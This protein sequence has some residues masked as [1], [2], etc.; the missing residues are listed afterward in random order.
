M[1]QPLVPLLVSAVLLSGCGANVPTD[2]SEE[3]QRVRVVPVAAETVSEELVWSGQITPAETVKLSF[4]VA[5][6]IEDVYVHAGETVAAGQVLAR[7][8]SADYEIQTRAAAAALQAATVQAEEILPAKLRQARAQLDLTLANY[9][10]IHSL[11]EAGAVTAVAL[12]EITAKKAVD[13]ATWTQA[14]EALRIGRAEAER[15][16]AAYDLPQ[17]NLAATEITSPWDGQVLQVI[18]AAGESTAAGYPVLALGSTADMWA[19]IGLTD[20][21]TARLTTGLTTDV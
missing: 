17:S 19:E 11:Y 3:P 6:V 2:R 15:A 10:R 13:E 5:G 12:D 18:A 21:E 14:A 8:Q 1:K 16:Q 20:A 4:K 7:L 9:E